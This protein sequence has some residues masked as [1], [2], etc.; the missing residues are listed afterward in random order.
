MPWLRPDPIAR[1][2]TMSLEDIAKVYEAIPPGVTTR[3]NL[4]LF[5]PAQ[6]PDLIGIED[7]RHLDHT[8]VVLQR[9]IADLMRYVALVQGA[10]SFDQFGDFSLLIRCRP[11]PCSNATATSSC[12]RSAVTCT[13]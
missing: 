1:I 7:R 2:D 8:G 6:I 12:T 10:N 9:S 13:R 4:S 5:A 3:V 11:R